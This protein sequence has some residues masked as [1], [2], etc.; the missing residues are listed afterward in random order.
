MN[1]DERMEWK[2]LRIRKNIKAKDVA[3]AM[4]ISP[5]YVSRFENGAFDWDHVLIRKYKNF[6]NNN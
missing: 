4:K 5:A 1:C 6:I 2:I 3:S